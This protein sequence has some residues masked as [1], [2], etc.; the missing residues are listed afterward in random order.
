MTDAHGTRLMFGGVDYVPAS[1]GVTIGS[2]ARGIAIQSSDP[3]SSNSAIFVVSNSTTP[4]A[5]TGNYGTGQSLFCVNSTGYV[6]GF[7]NV[8][9]DGGGGAS[10]KGTLTA[11]ALASTQTAAANTT[12]TLQATIPITVNGVAYKIM[13]TT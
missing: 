8:F 3:E 7:R 13:L 12:S 1:P 4:C 10:I 2:F 11:G 6:A 5:G 9:D